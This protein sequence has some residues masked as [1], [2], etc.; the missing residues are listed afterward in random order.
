VTR[1]QAAGGALA[2]CITLALAAP[3]AGQQPAAR[4][5]GTPRLLGDAVLP[6][7]VLE[8]AV[9]DRRA[10]PSFM[11]RQLSYRNVQ[12]ARIDAKHTLAALFRSRGLAFP[13][14]DV[15]LRVFK[16]EQL[17]ELWARGHPEAAYTHLRTYPMCVMPGRLGPKQREGDFQLPEGFY[18]IEVFNPQSRYNLSLG[19]DYPN[20]ADRLRGG[21]EPLGGDIFIHGG[22]ASE[23]CIPLDD[24]SMQ[25][26]YWLVVE[27]RAAGQ[28]RIPIHIFPTRLSQ[29]GVRWL[30]RV[31]APDA[32]T[33][34]FW[35]DLRSGF[36][37]FE[38][39]RRVPYIAVL[40]GG[41]YEFLD[42]GDAARVR[43]AMAR[44]SDG[45]AAAPATVAPA[46]DTGGD[47]A[48]V[49]ARLLGEPS[50]P[51][52]EPVAAPASTA[53]GAGPLP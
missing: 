14:S 10:E 40:E 52:R 28:R 41:R 20:P 36:D 25:E 12:A 38:K 21:T 17:V 48:S 7:A 11:Q 35:E 3:A 31:Y 16:Q 15:F 34:A 47:R 6:I 45:T 50:P 30:D 32:A 5:L 22:C 43:S 18:F 23:G 37:F 26:V 9:E 42:A 39:H 44:R 8:G 13:P 33:R 51:R 1:V 46:G 53:D 19:L 4:V 49:G 24:R 2:L 29:E 27:A